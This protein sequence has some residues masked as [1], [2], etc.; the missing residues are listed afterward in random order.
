MGVKIEPAGAGVA[1]EV[2]DLGFAYDTPN[3]PL[4]VLDHVSFDVP[5]GAVV[6][7]RGRSG[8]GKTTLLSLLGG[9]DQIDDGSVTVGEHDL[10][11]LTRNEI[12]A[13]RRDVVGFV[14]QDFGLLGQLTALENVELA[15]M[16]SPNPRRVRRTRAAELLDAVGLAERL[17]HRPRALS[18]G[19]K[20]RVAIARALANNPQLVLADEPTGNLDA[21]ATDNVLELL[22]RVPAD[23]GSTVIVVTHDET[24]AGAAHSQLHLL[25]GHFQP[26]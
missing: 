14:F 24:V 20:Q 17:G 18:G 15:L 16:F 12:A 4:V 23:H 9:L 3:G 21:D 19:E 22:L 2:R 5:A 6:A 13:Y 1:V 26:S 8:S 11:R 7:I 25:D 10:G